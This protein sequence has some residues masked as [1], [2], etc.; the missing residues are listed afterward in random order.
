MRVQESGSFARRWG[1][2]FG[3][4]LAYWIAGVS[5]LG[6]IALL[7]RSVMRWVGLGA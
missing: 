5:A 3:W 2:R 1:R 4:L 6:V 7:L